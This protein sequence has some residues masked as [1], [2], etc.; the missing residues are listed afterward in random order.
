MGT[1]MTKGVAF[2][3]GQ[4]VTHTNLNNLVDDAVVQ[5]GAITERSEVAVLQDADMLLVWDSSANALMKA[6]KLSVARA[7]SAVPV[8][9]SA[10]GTAGDLAYDSSYIYICIATDTWERASIASW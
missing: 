5:K 1:E 10:S 6:K 3:S 9:A 8:S 7:S 4:T 2:V